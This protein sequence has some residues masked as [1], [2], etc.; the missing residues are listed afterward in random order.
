MSEVSKKRKPALLALTALFIVAGVGYGIYWMTVASQREVTDNAYVGGNQVMLTSQVVGTVTEIRADETQLVTAGEGLIQLDPADAQLAL[1]QSRARLGETVRDLKKQYAATAQY[2]AALAQRRSDLTRARAD[3][4]RRVPLA[5]DQLV[6]AEELAHAKETQTN[7]E[8]ALDVTQKQLDAAR[9]GIEGVELI[10]HP[11]VEAARSAYVQ[12]WLASRRNALPAPVTGYVAKRNVQVGAR[13]TPG[14]ALMSIVPLDALWVD[15]NF[16]E[17]ELK[18]LRIGQP[19]ELVADAY[20]DDVTFHGKVV[21]LSAGTGSA[22]ALLPAQNATGNWIKVVQ[23]VPVRIALDAKELAE[24]PLRIGL[25]MEV[26]VDTHQRDGAVLAAK[27]VAAPLFKTQA[28]MQPLNEA[29]TE[30]DAIIA[31]NAAGARHG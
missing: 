18:H 30:A 26:K 5:K 22:F 21:G 16:K 23:R 28:F 11:A 2:E 31:R 14:Q 15:A 25:S 29:E 24:H 1:A 4:G 10:H 3:Y 7:A 20:G 9:A 8:L 19:V 27:P 13:V 12:A 17:S 6:A